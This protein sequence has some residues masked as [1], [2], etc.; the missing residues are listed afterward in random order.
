MSMRTLGG[1]RVLGNGRYSGGVSPVS[2][3]ALPRA[4]KSVVHGL[5]PNAST[6]SLD[7]GVSTPPS[8][9]TQ[10]LASIV[11]PDHGESSVAAP[12]A[13]ASAR[14]VCPICNEEMVTLLQL[15]RHL[16][17]NHG[18]IEEERQD[19]VKDWFKAQMVKAKKFQP[20]AVLNQKLK[21]LDVFESNDEATCSEEGRPASDSNVA[22]RTSVPQLFSPGPDE[23]V[24]TQHWQ[25]RGPNDACAEPTCGKRLTTTNGSV[26]CRHCGK[27]FCDEHTQYQMK[28]SRSG[29]H[30]PM[31]GIWGRVCETCYKSREGYNDKT[32][33]ERDLMPEFSDL[34]QRQAD[35]S[36]LEVSRLEK[37]LTRL[38]QL[39]AN[40]PE[41]VQQP[42]SKRW[43][44]GWTQNDLR[45]ALE[46]SVVTW[47]DD[48]AVARCLY[49][50]GEFTP[51]TFR[52]HHCRT[53]GKVVCGDPATGCS[54][55]VGLNVAT[56]TL[57]VVPVPFASML[58]GC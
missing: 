52:R 46:Q 9:G 11:S 39:L 57:S 48:T 20:L 47:Q 24:T 38:T 41:E 55:M 51:Y 31:H 53:C 22:S 40:P 28:L 43:S 2:F 18:E 19:E 16:D 33:L 10:D 32:G 5:S 35:K 29:L 34:R 12:V 21:G 14:L 42:A 44:I 25:K 8:S 17:D 4:P 6:L 36:Y 23:A 1:G 54:I 15:N 3:S 30:E 13:T 27:L 37:R 45:K 58:I 26:H 49:C 56:S 50:L 7:S